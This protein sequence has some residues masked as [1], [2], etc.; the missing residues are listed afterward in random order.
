MRERF[1]H[2][3]RRRAPGRRTATT[4]PSTSRPSVDGEECRGRLHHRHVL[5]GRL[6][7]PDGGPGRRRSAALSAGETATFTTALLAGRVRRRV[8]RRHR[9]RPLGEG[10]G[11]ARAGRRVRPDRQRVRHP[12]RAARRRPHPA[13]AR[14]GARAGRPGPRQAGRAPDRDRRGAAAGDGGRGEIEWRQHAFEHQLQQAG[15]DLDALPRSSEGE[16]REAFDAELRKNAEEAVSTQFILD[17]IADARSSPSTTTTS[18]AQ[19]IAQAQRTDGARAV[20]PAAAAGRQHRRR[21]SPTSAG[22]RRW[23]SC[24]SRRRSPT[25]RATPST[26]RRCARCPGPRTSATTAEA[27]PRRAS[28]RAGEDA[29][30][31][32]EPPGTGRRRRIRPEGRRP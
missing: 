10:E 22:P 30:R 9:H 21:S 18:P 5:R 15:M 20:R 4:S 24:W 11:A 6:R 1:A 28:R 14:Q 12:R 23:P 7:R 26:S 25:P 13:R 19:I 29:G 31:A 27:A 32:A 3:H 8:G 2:A 16:T 17:A